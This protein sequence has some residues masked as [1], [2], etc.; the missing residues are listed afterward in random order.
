M[1][2]CGRCLGARELK[3]LSMPRELARQTEK[4]LV[5]SEDDIKW[6]RIDLDLILVEM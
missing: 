2:R 5:R 3:T 4:Y 6:S 1:I